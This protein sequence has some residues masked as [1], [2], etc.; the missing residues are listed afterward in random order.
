M[1]TK[2]VALCMIVKGARD[3]LRRIHKRAM[4]R[5]VLM[6]D[7]HM[8]LNSDER[9]KY[10]ACT[11]ADEHRSAANEAFHGSDQIAWI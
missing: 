1:G 9:A 7:G 3:G 6:V 2:N 5:P 4:M 10:R 11:R 8:F